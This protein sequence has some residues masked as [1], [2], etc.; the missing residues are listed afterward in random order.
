MLS[1]LLS[2]SAAVGAV[3]PALL[4]RCVAARYGGDFFRALSQQSFCQQRKFTSTR[5]T[6]DS[7]DESTFLRLDHLRSDG[8]TLSYE[9]P[10]NVRQKVISPADAVALVRN[11]DTVCVSGFV[12]QGAA[13]AVLKALGERYEETGSPH[14][15]TLLFGGGPGDWETRGLNH[16]AKTK[17]EEG[18]PPMLRR[19][20][21]GHYGQVPKVA[22]L[23]L[24]ERTEAWVRTNSF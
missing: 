20:I 16:L 1:S 18:K 11:G 10:Q 7:D 6:F 17:D 23:A 5:R 22:E 8:P 13:E 9:I 2:T 3:R 15:L 14:S 24:A 12:S 19:T 4:A 21:G